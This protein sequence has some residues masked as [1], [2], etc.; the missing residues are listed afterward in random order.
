MSKLFFILLFTM[1]FGATS[2][3]PQI[4]IEHGD[5]KISFFDLTY[6]WADS[7]LG[8]MTTDEKIGQLF[9]VAA[10][11]NR[12]AAHENQIEQL[13]K[14]YQIGGLIFMQGGPVRQTRLTNNYQSISKIPLLIAMDAEWGPAMRLDSVISFQRQ[15]IWGAMTDDSVVY[16]AGSIIAKQLKRL[17]VHVNFAPVI[18]VNNN[19]NN[20]V[21]GDR[22]F[23]E[24]KINVA[25][26]GVA[27]MNALQENG[28]IAC[29]KHF[30]GH[31]DTDAD[32]HV[33]L[34]VINHSYKR[35]D[36]L[37]LFPF[38]ILMNEGL[39]S[40]MLA[41]LFIPSLDNTKNQASSLS[42]KVG[43]NLLRDSL[44]FHGLVFSDALNMK[45][46][47]AFYEPGELEVKAFEAGNDF[48]LFSENIPVAFNAIK[49]AVAVG[50]KKKS[51]HRHAQ[52]KS[53]AETKLHQTPL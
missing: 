29:G 37:E 18:D 21:I 36:S 40:I 2:F 27:Y 16:E 17:G 52:L 20:P 24:D 19:V 44:H 45:G 23:G 22:S 48:L 7:L 32:S 31:G 4:L 47:S 12:D 50:R 1:G 15:L 38:K 14:K 49:Q 28:I 42:E 41:H 30:P 53:A 43:I 33:S 5:D 8:G 13:I 51:Y 26:K 3:Q 6:P 11:S 9:M 10:Y 35:L 25:L 46:V 39:G 34:P